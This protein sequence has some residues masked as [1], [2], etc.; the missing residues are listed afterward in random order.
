MTAL[1][2]IAALIAGTWPLWLPFVFVAAVWLLGFALARAAG[3]PAPWEVD[4]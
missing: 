3:R 1:A 4:Q 2:A